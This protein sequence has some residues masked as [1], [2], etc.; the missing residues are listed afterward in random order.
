M[1]KKR[2]MANAK[3][4]DWGTTSEQEY[5]NAAFSEDFKGTVERYLL[6]GY[7]PGGFTTAILARD[8]ERALYSA[9]THN[10]KVFYW[11]ARWVAERMPP[12]SWGSYAEV[13]AWCRDTDGR[14]SRFKDQYEK[15]QVW[16]T[17]V[18]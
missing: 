7:E 14:R 5:S 3:L 11:I 12:G 8:F 1:I 16:L 18:K 13:E 9:D 2:A 15:E 10:R 4:V 6:H 17:L